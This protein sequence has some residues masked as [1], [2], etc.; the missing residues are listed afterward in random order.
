MGHFIFLLIKT[1]CQFSLDCWLFWRYAYLITHFQILFTYLIDNLHL[2]ILLDKCILPNWK[3]DL[4][5]ISHCCSTA[6]ADTDLLLWNMENIN[7]KR[8]KKIH[9]KHL[10]KHVILTK[11]YD[12]ALTKCFIARSNYINCITSCVSVNAEKNQNCLNK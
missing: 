10:L 8:Y 7:F 1:F 5:H 2:Y 12:K 3:Q 4:L 6:F 11:K 9:V